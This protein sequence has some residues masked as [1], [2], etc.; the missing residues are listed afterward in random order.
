[1]QRIKS[2]SASITRPTTEACTSIDA[3]SREVNRFAVPAMSEM[4]PSSWRRGGFTADR[5]LSDGLCSAVAHASVGMG[6]LLHRTIRSPAKRL[7]T[8]AARR[9][10][11]SSQA[12]SLRR[13]REPHNNKMAVKAGVKMVAL[14]RPGPAIDPEDDFTSRCKKSSQVFMARNS[15]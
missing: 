5:T 7:H 9:Q 12:R 6:D 1:M 2:E 4:G 3:P 13:L 14:T 11:R 15:Q 10:D 8:R